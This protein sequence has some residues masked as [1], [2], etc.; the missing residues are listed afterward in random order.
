MRVE[1]VLCFWLGSLDSR[2]AAGSSDV[3][4]THDIRFCSRGEQVRDFTGTDPD[5]NGRWHLSLQPYPEANIDRY[6]LTISEYGGAREGECALPAQFAGSG[7]EYPLWQRAVRPYRREGT[8]PREAIVLLRDESDGFHARIVRREHVAQFPQSVRNVLEEYDVCGR[9]L[10]LDQP[11]EV[12]DLPFTSV[13]NHTPP[14]L[15]E[16]ALADEEEQVEDVLNAS[17]ATGTEPVGER[18]RRSRV[19][20]E[21]LKRLYQFKCQL[22]QDDIPRID[23]GGGRYYVE[24]HHIEGYSEISETQGSASTTQ[25]DSE[26]LIDRAENIVVLCPYHHALLHHD[27]REFTFVVDRLA[28]VGKDETELPLM[29]NKHLGR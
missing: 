3:G 18:H 9:V 16:A 23:M 25:E 13:R 27:T 29:T 8:T 12:V 5:Q 28:F 6:E 24:V 17:G 7:S 19:L 21:K 1:A 10:L 20:A 15:L 26:L 2:V 22:C 11:L 14:F 4:G